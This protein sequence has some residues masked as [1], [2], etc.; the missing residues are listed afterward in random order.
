M[1]HLIFFTANGAE[2][3][4]HNGL[5][6]LKSM[7]KIANKH[8]QQFKT[9]ELILIGALVLCLFFGI[10]M[11]CLLLVFILVRRMKRVSKSR[12]ALPKYQSTRSDYQPLNSKD[13]DV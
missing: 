1:R 12:T 3:T 9:E 2:Y 5:M 7:P 6:F 8:Q 13:D 4:V 10:T 11:T